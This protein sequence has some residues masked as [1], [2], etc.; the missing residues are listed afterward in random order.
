MKPLLCSGAGVLDLRHTADDWTGNW[1]Q[2]R[3]KIDFVGRFH[4]SPTG[5]DGVV[6][7]LYQV[8]VSTFLLGASELTGMATSSI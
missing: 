4:G 3:C 2:P 8:K 7:F 6:A 5:V 1:P